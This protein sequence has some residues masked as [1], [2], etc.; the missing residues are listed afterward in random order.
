V[1]A[2]SS[3]EGGERKTGKERIQREAKKIG[4]EAHLDGHV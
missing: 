2:S 4:E 1:S 3:S